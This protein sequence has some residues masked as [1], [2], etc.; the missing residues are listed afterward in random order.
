MDLKFRAYTAYADHEHISSGL[1]DKQ[2]IFKLSYFVV[3]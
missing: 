2:G 1:W 3:A